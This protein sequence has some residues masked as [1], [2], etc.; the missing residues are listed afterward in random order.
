MYFY[1]TQRIL[2]INPKASKVQKYIRKEMESM[3]SYQKL[4]CLLL[5]LIMCLSMG[6][7]AFAA[8]G[9]PATPSDP[10]ATETPADPEA[11]SA[12]DS[13]LPTHA[14]EGPD[15]MGTEPN[16]D[17]V[18]T[19]NNAARGETYSLYQIFWLESYVNDNTNPPDPG[20]PTSPTDDLGNVT[21][22]NYAYKINSTWLWFIL[23][24]E[25]SGETGYVSVDTTT[26][27]VKWKGDATNARAGEFAMKALAYAKAN[28]IQPLETKVGPNV[29]AT[30]PDGSPK[31]DEKGQPVYL[32]ESSLSFSG[33]KLGYYLVD[34]SLG[35]LCSLDTTNPTV[36]IQDKNS[37]PTNK[38]QVNE[39]GQWGDKNDAEIGSKVYFN[40][41]V[42]IS[43]GLDHLV[44]HDIMAPGLTF[45]PTSVKIVY[46]ATGER[47]A[48]ARDETLKLG[49]HYNVVTDPDFD[50]AC[51]GVG[52]FHITFTDAFYNMITTGDH[53]LTIT[54]T[55][56]LNENAVVG[57]A[58]NKN[59]SYVSYG[60]HKTRTPDSDTY[61]R[62]WLIPVLKYHLTGANG[63]VETPLAGAI[64]TLS[65]SPDT[66]ADGKP[67][68]AIGLI[69]LGELEVPIGQD[70]QGNPIKEMRRCY[71][72]A[73]PEELANRKT[74][75][76]SE[77]V[78]VLD[79]I[80]TDDSGRFWVRGLD[81]G[82]YYMH[83]VQAPAGFNKLAAAIIVQI[84]SEGVLRQ[85]ETAGV[86]YI[87]IQ[88]GTGSEMP[89]TGGIGTTVFY[90]LGSILL[91]GAAV[92]LITKKRMAGRD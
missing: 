43:S 16:D 83:E 50:D 81:S 60:D 11:T 85:N 14:M 55:A 34:S 82:T 9:D 28:N 40:S 63:T 17:G 42:S 13:T 38:K 86:T 4:M 92:L 53:S 35:S 36:T 15:E 72:V 64:F 67:T 89:A 23:S 19:I 79:Q 52:T 73:T 66:D 5:A 58:G 57:A 30:N 33:L 26:G 51:Q 68:S 61:T 3:K 41:F 37:T 10:A 74:E 62:T 25:I 87:R 20:D 48:V 76:N 21:G 24:P 12:P 8:E 90:V 7:T 29:Q 75:T 1:L 49:D 39:A 32:P 2:K 45:D 18:I 56:T 54:Y 31:V 27:Y 77:G 46:D 65:K 44:Y 69:D 71:R 47:S 84:N 6:I 80:T 91:V 70:A 78:D 22:G 88:N 59:T